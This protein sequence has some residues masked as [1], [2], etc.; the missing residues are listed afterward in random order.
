MS[1]QHLDRRALL[2]GTGVAAAAATVAG[3]AVALSATPAFAATG[4][5]RPIS[6]YRAYDSREDLNGKVIEDKGA[7][8]A[9]LWKVPVLTNSAGQDQIP[10]SATAVAYNLTVVARSRTGFLTMLPGDINTAPSAS[11][12]NWG[13]P[14]FNVE[15]SAIANSGVVRLAAAVVESGKPATPGVVGVF[16]GG[17]GRANF[18]I[19]I[20]G[21]FV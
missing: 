17:G 15:G 20:N 10:A 3:G 8:S 14:N 12:I 19:D 7:N 4:A 1:D 21:Y 13:G 16:C 11:T 2:R 18:I 6:P 5:F 9:R